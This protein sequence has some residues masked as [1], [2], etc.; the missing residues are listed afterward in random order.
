MKS[1]VLPPVSVIIMDSAPYLAEKKTK[2]PSKY[3]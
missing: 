2:P 3:V 1:T